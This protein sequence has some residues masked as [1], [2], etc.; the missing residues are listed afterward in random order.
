MST[1]LAS[2]GVAV[3]RDRAQA[4]LA[5]LP[6]RWA[7][8]VGVARRAEEFAVILDEP[9][10]DLLVIA[11]WLH[12]IGYSPAVAVHGFHPL[13]GAIYLD[14]HGWPARVSALVAHHSEARFVAR[15]HGL[16]P[17][18]DRYPRELSAL[19]DA[20]TYADQTTG[21]T[22]EPLSVRA[23]MSEMLDR[24][25]PDSAQARVH[26]LRAARLLAAATRVRARL[27]AAGAPY[28]AGL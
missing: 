23:R 2:A 5:D 22:G 14:G 24:H 1:R 15:E 4:L 9:E 11:A 27:L 20:L 17:A 10:H 26:H 12:D 16:Q 6:D 13:D 3:A 8:T 21:P 19:A 18:T 7:H 28:A 25:G